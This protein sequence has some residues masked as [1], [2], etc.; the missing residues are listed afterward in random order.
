[1]QYNF[2]F[3]AQNNQD[4]VINCA[5]PSLGQQSANKVVFKGTISSKNELSNFILKDVFSHSTQF[6]V[7]VTP[8]NV[9]H[10]IPSHT[11]GYT[12]LLSLEA[13]TELSD[14][15]FQLSADIEN[16]TQ[17][18]GY[19]FIQPVDAVED[20]VFVV[21]SPRSGTSALGKAIRKALGAQAH[22]ESHVVEGI[23]RIL[24]VCQQH[25]V[26]S[27][28]AQIKNNL[29][30]TTPFTVLL[31]EQLTVLRNIYR[32]N[33]GSITHLDKTP[34]IP[35]L[36]S[37][38]VAMMAWPNAKVIFCKRRAL[39]NVA[40]RLVKF[41]KVSFENHLKQWK[42]SF[43]IW[44]KSRQ[45]I[46]HMLKNQQWSLEVEQETM[47]TRPQEVALQAQQHL[48]LSAKRKDKLLSSL[49]G[50]RP[51]QTSKLSQTIRGLE[52]MGWTN[53]Q[54]QLVHAICGEEL[55]RQGYSLN[56]NYY[57]EELTNIAAKAK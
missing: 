14:L 21:G 18:L 39:E 7:S 42:Q 8:Y 48:K 5:T 22:G 50:T 52:D 28:T 33:Y 45:Q 49:T 20:V 17:P 44:R 19:G 56:S 15:H 51:E 40:S 1:M 47:S 13:H 9:E 46:N 31:A 38:P 4:I 6:D 24:D 53:E 11:Y 55:K 23:Q 37:L 27:K 41:P 26:D 16:Q 57:A 3:S 43:V 10:N 2:Y 29:V 25:F 32:L 36:R 12:F 30:N 54:K 34:G 35:M